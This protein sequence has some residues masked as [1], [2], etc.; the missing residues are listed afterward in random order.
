MLGRPSLETAIVNSFWTQVDIS[1]GSSDARFYMADCGGKDQVVRAIQQAGWKGYEPP[2]P[3]LIA[4]LSFTGRVNFIDIGANT[5][6][7][8]LLAAVCGAKHVWAF[9]PVSDIRAIFEANIY[10]SALAS[11]ITVIAMALGEQ[12]GE[13]DLFLPD[14]GHG[15]IETSASLNPDFREHHSS[16]FPVLVSTLDQYFN[17]QIC[18]SDDQIVLIKIDVE[19]WEKQVIKG[20]VQFIAIHRPIMVMELLPGADVEFFEAFVRNQNYAHY[21]LHP[22]NGLDESGQKFELSLSRRDHLFVPKEKMQYIDF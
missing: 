9:E 12:S 19:S 22:T 13:L 10:E 2:L 5:G 8:S 7:Y 16:K 18:S 4:R 20:G 21:W 14:A 11:K 1:L 15:L 17:E 6:Y 3:L